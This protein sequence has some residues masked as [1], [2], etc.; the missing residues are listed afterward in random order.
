MARLSFIRSEQFNNYCYWAVFAALSILL[1]LPLWTITYL[2]LGDL[3][4]HAGQLNAIMHYSDY[5]NEYRI[6]WFTPYLVGYS[7]S[8]M[9]GLFFSATTALKITYTL[10]VLAVPF[11]TARLLRNLGLNRYWVIPSFASAFSFSFYWGF[12][13]YVVATPIAIAFFAFC[14]LYSQKQRDIK[15][16]TYAAAFSALLFFAHAMAWAFAMV[17]AACIIFINNSL[18]ETR[19]KLLPFVYL[20]PLVGY[21]ISVN[22]ATQ[23]TSVEAGHLIEHVTSRIGNELGYVIEQFKDR[24]VK[25]EHQQRAKE[26]LSFAIGRMPLGD[27]IVLSGILLFWPLLI[28]ARLTRNWR[29]WLPPLCAVGAFMIVPYWIFDTAYVNLRFA[30][31]LMPLSLFLFEVDSTRNPFAHYGIVSFGIR[32]L[33]GIGITCLLLVG[34]YNILAS[35]KSND[36]DFT[37]ILEKMEPNKIVLALMFDQDSALNFAP[38]YMHYASYYQAEKGGVAVANFSHDPVAHNVPLRYRGDAWILPSTWNPEKFDWQQHNGSRYDYF[39]IRSK[40]LRD[41]L[42]AQ[43]SGRVILESRQGDW[44]LYKNNK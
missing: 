10:A 6:N 28:G 43:S 2:P 1:I 26:L 36:A 18:K 3:P 34:N 30:V 35:F 7:I 4:D 25:H 16:L 8:L 11:T 13:S 38:P 44:L 33:S 17:V 40:T 32:C 19:D 37:A 14:V 15:T 42:F 9:F 41:N 39:L 12:F 20:L 5:S 27:Y 31:F 22:G 29:K 21:W 24:T 23:S